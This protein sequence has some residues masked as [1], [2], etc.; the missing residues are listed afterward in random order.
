MGLTSSI[1]EGPLASKQAFIS[2]VALETNRIIASVAVL[3]SRNIS[4]RSVVVAAAPLP[5]LLLFNKIILRPQERYSYN[6]PLAGL[7]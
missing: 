3:L 2:L 6:K 4:V 1:T 5:L 7:L